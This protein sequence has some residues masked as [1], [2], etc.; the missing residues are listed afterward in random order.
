M[1]KRKVDPL[2]SL[3]ECELER[4][5]AKD[6]DFKFNFSQEHC[7]TSKEHRHL[8]RPNELCMLNPFIAL[9]EDD[10]DFD[11]NQTI[12]VDDTPLKGV[13]NPPSNC[14]NPL[15]YEGDPN[16]IEWVATLN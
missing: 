7:C 5:G 8:K 6:F 4:Q 1:T 14:I 9:A 12:L 11:P 13:L 3:I 2:V 16:E 15:T 10:I